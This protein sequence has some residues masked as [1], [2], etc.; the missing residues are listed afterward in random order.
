MTVSNLGPRGLGATL[1]S[2]VA[3]FKQVANALG[4]PPVDWNEPKAFTF[5]RRK[6]EGVWGWEIGLQ[7]GRFWLNLHCD[8]SNEAPFLLKL[9]DA[10]AW[11]IDFATRHGF[12]PMEQRR[13]PRTK[14]RPEL[15]VI[16]GGTR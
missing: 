12:E 13:P 16:Q 6:R 2:H 3:S 7:V 4:L 1:S 5:R 10:R 8:S 15:R 11:A 14:P 9:N